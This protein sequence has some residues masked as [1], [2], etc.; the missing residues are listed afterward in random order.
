MR[1]QVGDRV[2]AIRDIQGFEIN[3]LTGIVVAESQYS[4]DVVGVAFDS[5]VLGAH[6][7]NGHCEN[8][9]GLWVNEGDLEFISKSTPESTLKKCNERE[10]LTFATPEQIVEVV[11]KTEIGSTFAINGLKAVVVERN[12]GLVWC[13]S[14]PIRWE[15]ELFDSFLAQYHSIMVDYDWSMEDFGNDKEHPSQKGKAFPISFDDWR[16]YWDKMGSF[17][18]VNSIC[19][20][21]RLSTGFKNVPFVVRDIHS[22]RVDAGLFSGNP[23]VWDDTTC[24][25]FAIKEET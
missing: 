25:K 11:N 10:T 18:I 16:K 8:G 2:R 15:N 7:L 21:I 5:Y 1:F 6:N 13:I 20:P 4:I 19:N 12:N 14:E 22:R 23:N 17:K 9:Y 24:V 3:S